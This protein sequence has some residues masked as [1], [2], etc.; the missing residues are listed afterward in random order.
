[1][2]NRFFGAA[3]LGLSA[4]WL[5]AGCA[6]IERALDLDDPP[7]VIV[8]P[9]PVLKPQAE[10]PLLPKVKPS[11]VKKKSADSQPE[12]A[13]VEP[14]SVPMAQEEFKEPDEVKGKDEIA[15]ARLFG[16]PAR[17]RT[18]GAGQVWSF[19]AEEC[20]LDVYFFLDVADNRQR[21]LSYEFISSAT[22]SKAVA[23]CY[24]KLKVN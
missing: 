18:E 1:M 14:A 13:A 10:L 17:V 24:A 8:T 20:A 2:T 22:D 6:E 4:A 7:I 11:S 12:A 16:R 5:L 19:D 15:V 21:A 23:A 9:K 3:L